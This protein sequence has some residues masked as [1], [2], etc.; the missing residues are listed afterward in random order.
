[1]SNESQNSNFSE[2]ILPTTFV[3]GKEYKLR[4]NK[5]HP[6]RR[7]RG[8]NIPSD[9]IKVDYVGIYEYLGNRGSKLHF[10]DNSA[11]IDVLLSKSDALLAL[12]NDL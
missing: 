9:Y 6:S 8:T 1:M 7:W 2:P 3:K 10:Y 12:K 11:G 5:T 4:Y